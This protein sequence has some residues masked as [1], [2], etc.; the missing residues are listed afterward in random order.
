MEKKLARKS[1]APRLKNDPVSIPDDLVLQI[2]IRLPVKSLL[3]FRSVCKSWKFMVSDPWFVD[4]HRSRS[5]TTLLISFP[6][7]RRFNFFC[8]KDG[9]VSELSQP[10]LCN[11]SQSING[12]ICI[13]EQYEACSRKQ[14]FRVILC[15]PSTREVVTLPPTSFPSPNYIQQYISL[16]YDPSTGT[17]KI[18]RGW[19]E[20][21]GAAN[22]EIFTLGSSHAWRIIKD[23]PYDPLESKEICVSG[24]IYWAPQARN[25]NSVTA[26][27]VGEEKF[28]SVAVPPE[29]PLWDELNTSIIQIDGRMAIVDYQDVGR[30]ISTVMVIWKLE[31]SVKG[32]WSQKRILVPECWV[33]RILTSP[34]APPFCIASGDSGYITLIPNGFFREYF[35]VH[36]NIEEGRLWREEI[37]PPSNCHCRFSIIN[38]RQ[39]REYVKSLLSLKKICRSDSTLP[40]S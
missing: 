17:Y 31:D 26:F 32:V 12:L 10:P 2:L 8:V 22:Y 20:I 23:G 37:N 33:E 1:Y 7:I 19:L 5:A 39:V 30:R 25:G 27:D 14:L 16:G 11:I 29:A 13:Y 6:E 9:E 38:S 28:R 24:T 15:N 3:R 35:I 4:A 40:P 21:Y 34:R 36:W 18:L